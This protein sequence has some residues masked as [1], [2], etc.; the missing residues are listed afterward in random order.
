[1]VRMNGWKQQCGRRFDVFCTSTFCMLM[2]RYPDDGDSQL[3][4]VTN[5]INKSKLTSGEDT[6]LISS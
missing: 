4:A 2:W 6:V 5:I 3:I 1:M